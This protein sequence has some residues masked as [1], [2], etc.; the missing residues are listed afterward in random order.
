MEWWVYSRPKLGV[1]ALRLVPGEAWEVAIELER[2][3]AFWEIAPKKGRPMPDEFP[4]GKPTRVSIEG[5]TYELTLQTW[6]QMYVTIASH[7]VSTGP[8]YRGNTP[9]KLPR[10]KK[11]L[12][13][14][15]SEGFRVPVDIGCGS[16][17]S[18]LLM[19]R[20]L[21]QSSSFS[22]AALTL[23]PS[24]S[25]LTRAKG[26]ASHTGTLWFPTFPNAIKPYAKERLW[27]ATLWR[28]AQRRVR[29]SRL[30]LTR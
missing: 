25:T 12:V 10:A 13:N 11:A 27:L 18:S 24:E 15:S 4:E 17:D 1:E 23:R 19:E 6:K 3:L 29:A 20:K 16:R 5:M 26:S 28:N 8:T 21:T 9:I 7:L 30:K 2:R 22:I 14:S